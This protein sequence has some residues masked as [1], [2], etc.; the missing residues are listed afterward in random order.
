M[1]AGN[2][3]QNERAPVVKTL[4]SHG[5]LPDLGLMAERAD[6]SLGVPVISA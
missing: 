6:F 3:V 2:S 4:F 1:S 5:L